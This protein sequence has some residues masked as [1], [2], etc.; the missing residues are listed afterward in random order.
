M[1]RTPVESRAIRSV[2]YDADARTLEVEFSSG[3]VYA[4]DGVEPSLYE[5][6]LRVPNKGA[7]FNRLVKD[8]HPER[9]VT[10]PPPQPDLAALLARSLGGDEPDDA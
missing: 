3:R 2:G 9:D 5:W 7:V 6:L 8:R 4:Y 1:E 10:P